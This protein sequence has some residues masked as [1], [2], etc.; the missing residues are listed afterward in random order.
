MLLL[1]FVLL[2]LLVPAGFMP[3]TQAGTL[4]LG[5]CPG[6]AAMAGQDDAHAMHHDDHPGQGQP[7][8][9]HHAPCA[10]AASAAAASAPDLPAL[11]MAR[12]AQRAA[13]LPAQALTTSIPAIFRAQSPRAPPSSR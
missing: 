8:G 9:D 1:P 3:M 7:Q 10:F 4:S 2:R 13:P 5:L 11:R 12:V 6:E